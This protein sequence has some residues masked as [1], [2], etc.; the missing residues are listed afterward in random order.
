MPVSLQE[1][2][3]VARYCPPKYLSED[4]SQILPVAFHLRHDRNEKDL[5]VFWVEYYGTESESI[6]IDELKK[7]LPATLTPVRRSLL[8][9]ICVG[10]AIK[11][12]QDEFSVELSFQNTKGKLKSHSSIFGMCGDDHDA[13]AA[14]L[15]ELANKR[16]S[17]PAN[18]T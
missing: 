2:H 14:E 7:Q 16:C 9:I 18:I 3:S 8:G 12:V 15:T 11:N 1:E 17:Y 5:S 6:N 4:Q 13:I 10:D